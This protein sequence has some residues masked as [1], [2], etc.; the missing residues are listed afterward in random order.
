MLEIRDLTKVYRRGT[1]ANDGISLSVAAGEVLGLLG[2]NGAGKTT[3]LGQI[4]G[5]VKPTGGEIRLRGRDPVADPA[6][7]RRVC[8][9]QPQSQAPLTGVTVRQ[10]IEIVGRIRGGRKRDVHA[11]T[12]RLLG[13]LEIEEWADRPAERVSGG[14]RRLTAF[15]MAVVQPGDLVML[16][17]PTNDVDPVRRRLLGREVRRLADAGHAVVVV[18]HNITEAERDLDRAVILDRGR[19]VSDDPDVT[20]L[21]DRYLRLI[22]READDV[23]V[24]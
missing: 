1:R 9:F 22:G 14:V 11:A 13:A 21:E 18:T 8:S 6:Y 20:G 24:A 19:V 2:H 5:L 16:D 12:D 15:G 17:E 23:L 7:A 4:V 10:A 3:L